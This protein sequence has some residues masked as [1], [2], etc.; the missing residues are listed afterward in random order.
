MKMFNRATGR[1]G[2]SFA[3][4]ALKNK[5]YTILEQNFG[6]KF[7]EIDIIAKDKDVLVFVEV[8]TKIGEEFGLPEE[9]VGPGK[10]QKIRHMATVYMKG[11]E[12][13]CRIDVV[14]IVLDDKNTVIRLTHYENVY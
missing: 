10:L 2:E 5:G 1:V 12:I 8:K 11:K 13:P 4:A 14:A 9:M 7:G 6:S 3:E